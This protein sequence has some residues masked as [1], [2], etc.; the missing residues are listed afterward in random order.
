M[1]TDEIVL[2]A[3]GSTEPSSFNELCSGLDRHCPEERSEWAQL[4]K[5]IK[6]LETAKLVEVTRDGRDIEGLQLTEAGA[7][8]IRDR[9]D[10]GRA[11]LQV[12]APGTPMRE[13]R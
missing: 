1:L 2:S 13:K 11:L 6:K 4:F 5:I 12:M 7:N 8:R 10:A 3:I 9:K